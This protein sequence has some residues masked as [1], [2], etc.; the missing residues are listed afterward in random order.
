MKNKNNSFLFPFR[1]ETPPQEL[2]LCSP[3]QKCPLFTKYFLRAIRCIPVKEYKGIFFVMNYI[4]CLYLD[5][6]E[7]NKAI[8]LYSSQTLS[9][10]Q[11]EKTVNIIVIVSLHQNIKEKENNKCEYIYRGGL[12]SCFFL[13]NSKNIDPRTVKI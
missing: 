2:F 10:Y 12:P 8:L 7:C 11:L 4:I 13:H 1:T 6:L 3:C 5:S 9:V